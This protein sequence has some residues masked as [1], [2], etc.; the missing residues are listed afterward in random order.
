MIDLI[1]QL[2]VVLDNETETALPHSDPAK[3][4]SNKSKHYTGKMGPTRSIR[5]PTTLAIAH[6]AMNRTNRNKFSKSKSIPGNV[7]QFLFKK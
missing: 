1:A 4:T 5:S 3:L 6:S 2:C 7:L